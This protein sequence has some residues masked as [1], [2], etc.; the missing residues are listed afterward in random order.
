MATETK[1]VEG[2]RGRF[3]N[4]DSAIKEA[5]AIKEI[6]FIVS[7]P[8][9][10]TPEEIQRRLDAQFEREFTRLNQENAG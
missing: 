6:A 7:R 2:R 10:L 4:L 8:K 3:R 9:N 5:N 1:M